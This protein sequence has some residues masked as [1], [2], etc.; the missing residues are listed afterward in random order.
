[1]R[2]F[3]VRQIRDDSPDQQRP[4]WVSA[5]KSPLRGGTP[6]TVADGLIAAGPAPPSPGCVDST[7][8]VVRPLARPGSSTPF[9]N[10][11]AV[12]GVSMASVGV[13]SM[14]FLQFEFVDSTPRTH[15]THLLT[16]VD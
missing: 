12:S 8:A 1:M 2:K 14:T 13:P 11:A 7:V 9:A 4:K 3:L 10:T 15:L 16:P 5:V 6:S